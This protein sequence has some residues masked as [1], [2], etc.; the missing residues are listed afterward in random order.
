MLYV[1][2][3]LLK[4]K[5]HPFISEYEEVFKKI[6]GEMCEGKPRYIVA[7][8]RKGPR[9]FDLFLRDDY[10][11]QHPIVVSDRGI[12]YLTLVRN[13]EVPLFDDIVIFGS[14][15]KD[16][17]E[18]LKKA[19]FNPLPYSL[20]Y[21]IDEARIKVNY[22]K[23]LSR[24]YAADFCD[25]ITTAFQLLAKPFDLDHPIFTSTLDRMSF[26]QIKN[27]IINELGAQYFTDMTNNLQL[28]NGISNLVFTYP[29]PFTLKSLFTTFCEVHPSNLYKIRIF[30]NER[31]KKLTIAPML[32]FYIRFK[33]LDKQFFVDGLD[34]FNDIISKAKEIISYPK[35]NAEE[36]LYRLIS[37][38][39][40]YLY[41]ISFI[42]FFDFS[43]C[44]VTLNRKDVYYLYGDVFGEY[45]LKMLEVKKA[46]IIDDFSSQTSSHLLGDTAKSEEKIEN[47]KLFQDLFYGDIYKGMSTIR[48]LLKWTNE[49]EGVWNICRL[50]KVIDYDTRT[51]DALHSRGRLK[52]GFTFEDYFS[53]LKMKIGIKDHKILST[54]IDYFIDRGVLVPLFIKY[55]TNCWV[56]AYRFGENLGGYPEV[57]R[58]YFVRCALERLFENIETDNISQFD[59][60]KFLAYM[61]QV[62]KKLDEGWKELNFDIA[63]DE[64]GARPITIGFRSVFVKNG[65]VIPEKR[66][67]F[68]EA[69]DNKVIEV[70][71]RR[72]TLGRKFYIAR[73]SELNPLS[74][75]NS[76]IA[77]YVD[78]WSK[79]VYRGDGKKEELMLLLTTCNNN[80]NFLNSYKAGLYS[81]FFHDHSRFSKV[82]VEI[83]SILDLKEKDPTIF[84]QK[85]DEI[86]KSLIHDIATRLKQCENKRMVWEKREDIINR[87]DQE[88]AKKTFI[89]PLWEEI[90]NLIIDTST[91][92][93][94]QQL[95]YG[96]LLGFYEICRITINVLRSALKERERGELERY[97]NM[98]NQTIENTRFI[99]GL[100]LISEKNLIGILKTLEYNYP[101]MEQFFRIK[102]LDHERSPIPLRELDQDMAL[103]MYD[104]MGFSE[105]SEARREEISASIALG[106]ENFLK[107]IREEKYYRY[108][109]DDANAL[110]L[111]SVENAFK[112][113]KHLLE[114]LKEQRMYARIAIHYTDQNTRIKYSE[115][116]PQAITG[117]CFIICARLRDFAEKIQKER[118]K[119]GVI[120]NV[121]FITKNV[122]EQLPRDL[123]EGLELSGP[124]KSDRMHGVGEIEYWEVDEKKLLK[125]FGP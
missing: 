49:V 88:I 65:Q 109:L 111:T 87:L 124:F 25:D 55:P 92:D 78:L 73:P 105:E 58:A 8:A 97:I 40:E 22:G 82:L 20:A 7:I 26:E 56:R 83:K 98:Y 21:N 99:P 63:F 75:I 17:I 119:R 33:D 31:K 37:Y 19:G 28:N 24:K 36:V 120:Q 122:Y 46:K 5:V 125:I 90:K 103:V 61:I 29:P 100:S 32:I 3:I 47:I 39:I 11:I 106:M 64:F 27:R 2:A 57:K 41:G 69:Q 54:V 16:K 59:F 94:K 113:L 30:Y 96:Y 118:A 14:T 74:R 77:L 66:F 117:R 18:D 23:A 34:N 80:H 43:S 9:L 10:A 110:V 70:V 60:E 71:N 81:W 84:T 12:P 101:L 89:G 13:E 35:D 116:R 53:I 6:F 44:E 38:L 50:M 93:E 95:I 86:D 123:K 15:M 114:I 85:V 4:E 108:V 1:V 67:L 68:S 51:L 79:L 72:I 121:I 42:S 48:E 91:L 102:I 112:S 104:L 107:A 115:D 76:K 52:F 45:L 62:F